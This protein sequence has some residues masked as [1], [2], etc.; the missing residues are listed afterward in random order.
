MVKSKSK[1]GSRKEFVD[2][3]MSVYWKN[4][5]RNAGSTLRSKETRRLRMGKIKGRVFEM[6]G[7]KDKGE[8][9]HIDFIHCI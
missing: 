4:K 3:M 6:M 1:T 7:D 9:T 2:T 5:A 8:Y